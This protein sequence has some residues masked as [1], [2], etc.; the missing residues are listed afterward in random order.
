MPRARVGVPVALPDGY[1]SLYALDGNGL[2]PDADFVTLSNERIVTVTASATP[3][4]KGAWTALTASAAA[5]YGGLVL[6][7]GN[8]FVTATNTAILMDVGTGTAGSEV[9]R[10]PNI[11]TGHHQLSAS[12]RIARIVLPFAIPK[13]TRVAARMQS[14]V[15]SKT[16]TVTMG[17][18]LTPHPTHPLRPA[19]GEAYGV[20]LGTSVGTSL[21]WAGAINTKGAWVTLAAATTQPYRA[22]IC[23]VGTPTATVQGAANEVIDFGVGAAG[24]ERVVAPNLHVSTTTTE[25]M[26]GERWRTVFG[27]FPAGIRVAARFAGSAATPLIAASVIGIPY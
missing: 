14:I 24:S 2:R 17:H 26:D 13:G 7:V 16:Q 19:V 8:A 1:A 6:K 3:H 10:I 25:A 12:T 27:H 4:T 15:A 5:D 23:C 18:A 20:D 21:T 9:V 11:N 22:I